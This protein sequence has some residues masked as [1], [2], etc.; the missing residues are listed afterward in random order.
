MRRGGGGG[1]GRGGRGRGRRG[2]P[3]GG[4]YD[5]EY[6][7]YDE[8]GDDRYSNNNN[9]MGGGGGGRRGPN[10]RPGGR[11]ENRNKPPPRPSNPP[12]KKSDPF[13]DVWGEVD[14]DAAANTLQEKDRFGNLISRKSTEKSDNMAKVTKRLT[15]KIA[16]CVACSIGIG[17]AVAR[18]LAQE[19]AHVIIVSRKKSQVDTAVQQLQFEGLNASGFP[20]NV[21]Q[22]DERKALLNYVKKEFKRVDSLFLNQGATAGGGTLMD[23]SLE[24]FNKVIETN[25]LSRWLQIKEFLPIMPSGSSIVMTNGTGAYSPSS[26]AGVFYVSETALLGMTILLA[27]ELGQHGIRVNAIAPGPVRTRFATDL[28]VDKD[29][30]NNEE[31]NAKSIWLGRIGEPDDIAGSVAFMMSDDAAWYTGQTMS[32]DGGSYS[33]L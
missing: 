32:V 1:R 31:K 11:R 16:L 17:Y 13:G 28:W 15:D 3:G 24:Q 25:I 22:E 19:G 6:D 10:G 20:C 27:K 12:P 9:P 4:R 2:R 14:P 30:V 26:T 5:N 23:S 33:R 8:Y 18:R 7:E 29:G 21:N